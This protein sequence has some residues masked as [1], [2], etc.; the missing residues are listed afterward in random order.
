[1]SLKDCFSY[2][3]FKGGGIGNIESNLTKKNL[4]PSTLEAGKGRAS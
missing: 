2:E 1:M 4:D 3:V